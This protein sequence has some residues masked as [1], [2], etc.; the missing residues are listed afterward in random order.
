[1]DPLNPAIDSINAFACGPRMLGVTG[2]LLKSGR[3]FMSWRRL[4]DGFRLLFDKETVGKDGSRSAAAATCSG[5]VFP[6]SEELVRFR[7]TRPEIRK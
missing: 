3:G 1:M 6:A 2:V 4:S 7:F 5:V